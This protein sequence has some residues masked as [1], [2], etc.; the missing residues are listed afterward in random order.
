M[1]GVVIYI[2]LDKEPH[3]YHIKALFVTFKNPSQ[4]AAGGYQM[5]WQTVFF[6]M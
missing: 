1:L 6:L 3:G 4:L 5:S 2:I